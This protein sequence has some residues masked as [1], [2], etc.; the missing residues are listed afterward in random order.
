MTK[1]E[2]HFIEKI[3]HFCVANYWREHI[4]KVIYNKKIYFLFF[5]NKYTVKCE[6]L[7]N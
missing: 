6:K 2:K 5:L 4:S 7:I 3:F 1:H